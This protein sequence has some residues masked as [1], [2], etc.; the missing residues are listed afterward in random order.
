MTQAQKLTAMDFGDKRSVIK[1]GE[2]I[3][4]TLESDDLRPRI[5]EKYGKIKEEITRQKEVLSDQSALYSTVVAAFIEEAYEPRL[6][7]ADAINEITLQ[8][9]QGADS[10]KIPTE[11][12]MTAQQINAD[13]SFGSGEDTSGFNSVTA[14]VNWYGAYT[15][16]PVPLIRKGNV[17]LIGF[18]LASIGRAIGRKVDSVIISEMKKATD[19]NDGT[20]GSASN[21]NYLGS[22]NNLSLSDFWTSYWNMLDLDA[23]PDLLVTNPTTA[24]NLFADSDMISALGYASTPDVAAP[25]V[26]Q[27]GN[28][29]LLVSSQVSSNYAALVD[30]D[31]LGYMVDAS[32]IESWDSRIAN[33]FQHEVMGTKAMGVAIAKEGSVYGI[34]EDTNEP[35]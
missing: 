1:A 26:N 19:K 21:Y 20:Y 34:Y 24:S 16:L 6:L 30:S 7:A 28:L 35:S 18:R 29:R 33:K 17:D 11:T 10:V 12:Q 27:I 4:R 3:T 14:T 5:Q 2:A 25:R 31:E 9:N 8:L 15:D 13:G 22:G 23:E 32:D